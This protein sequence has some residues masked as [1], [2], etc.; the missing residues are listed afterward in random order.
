MEPAGMMT[1]AGSRSAQPSS[2]QVRHLWIRK[3]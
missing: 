3:G 1:S 2:R